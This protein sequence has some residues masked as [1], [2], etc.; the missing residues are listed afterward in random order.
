MF[1]IKKKS[2]LA[3][4]ELIALVWDGPIVKGML[5]SYVYWFDSSL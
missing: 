1:V 4:C 2:F 3:L 5:S